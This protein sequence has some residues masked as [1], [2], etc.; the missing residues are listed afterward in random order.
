MKLDLDLKIGMNCTVWK[1]QNFSVIQIL[2]EINFGECR[3]YESVVFAILEALNLVDFLNLS[4][5]KVTKYIKIK[6]QSL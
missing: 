6:I 4:F 2:R 3:N 5:Q 1:F